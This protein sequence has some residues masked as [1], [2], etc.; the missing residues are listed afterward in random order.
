MWQ[1]CLYLAGV[2]VVGRCVR[3]F[4]RVYLFGRGLFIW[5]D[6]FIVAGAHIFGREG[7]VQ[8]GWV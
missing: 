2:Y 1:V 5:Q 6:I 3:I 4:G 8:Q 7:C